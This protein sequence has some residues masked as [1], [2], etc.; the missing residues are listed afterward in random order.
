MLPEPMIVNHGVD[1]LVI[2]A[3]CTEAGK[4]VKRELPEDLAVLL[5]GK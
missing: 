5:D 1:T 2:N 3:Y 4:P